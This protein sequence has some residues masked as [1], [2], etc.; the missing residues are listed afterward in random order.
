[1]N[2]PMPLSKDIRPLLPAAPTGAKILTW[3]EIVGV[4]RRRLWLIILVTC[5]TTILA[6]LWFVAAYK[7]N[8]WPGQKYT[9]FAQ[10]ECEM[11]IRDNPLTGTQMI[12]HRDLIELETHTQALYLES[13][14]FLN[15]VLE[16]PNVQNTRWHK[17]KS[18]PMKRMKFFKSCFNAQE[19]RNSSYITLSM[20]TSN[21]RESQTILNEILNQF[22][23]DI[24]SQASEELRDRRSALDGQRNTVLKN[25]E[26][27]NT[28]MVRILSNTNEPG[29]EEGQSSAWDEYKLMHNENLILDAQV[30]NADM[31]VRSM[32]REI[33]K[34]GYSNAVQLDVENNPRVMFL[35]NQIV[36]QESRLAQIRQ[37]LGEN[38]QQVKQM[39]ASING[40]L[41][42]LY[43]L[44]QEL[45]VQYTDMQL[46]MIEREKLSKETQRQTAQ[47]KYEEAESD[48]K[49]LN[50]SRF[51]FLKAQA[52]LEDLKAQLRRLDDRIYE[53]DI[54]RDNTGG[55]TAKIRTRATEPLGI[56]SP[57]PVI[58]IP[59]GVALGLVISV[60]LILLLEFVDDSVK[61]PSD[62][63]R[64][65]NIPLLGMIPRHED[66]DTDLLHLAKISYNQPQALISE[67]FRQVRTNLYFSAPAEEMKTILITSSSAG[68]GKTT[69]AV[70]L[71][72]TLATEGKR[73]LLVDANFRRAAINRLFGAEGPPRGLSN[74][75][76]G[77]VPAAEVIRPSE[78]EGLDL[79]DAGPAPPNPAVLLSGSRM[80][81][82]LESQKQYYDHII[83]DGPPMLVVTDARIIA[84]IVD[85]AIAVV[86]AGD[87]S[88]GVVQRMMGELKNN[89]VHMLGVL[90]NAVRALKG[91]YFSESYKS[92]YEYIG[93]E[94][95]VT[96]S[97]PPNT[98]PDLVES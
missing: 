13:E 54:Q 20:T 88:R 84:G 66:A 65:L 9:S 30:S 96:K 40:L 52:E 22:Q 19:Q 69:V 2:K 37:R 5:L 62:V 60:G 87:T 58:W 85:G 63:R 12:P 21:P 38:H 39:Q 51:E 17:V 26:D 8:V 47:A 57:R 48:L 89:Q 44:R 71:A 23:L 25:I 10:I 90:L 98:G 97:L 33:D 80:Q 55:A 73:I 46:T 4:F 14:S 49:D 29:F 77:Q 82:F 28:Q 18:I 34:F 61:S 67:A 72:I 36:D 32:Q 59:L 35:S 76:V 11:P 91:G 53:L 92:Y 75:L 15:S 94:T 79:V 24:G 7:F 3:R 81:D 43:S 6:A 74:I 64:Y 45:L 68:C 95:T 31:M 1:M 86:H 41:N 42:R 93:A 70:N 78:I 83:L 27:K 16:R 50:E 56:S